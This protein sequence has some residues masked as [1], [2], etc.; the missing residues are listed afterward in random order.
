MN[1][2]ALQDLAAKLSLFACS[3]RVDVAVGSENDEVV[4]SRDY[5]DEFLGVVWFRRKLE[6][7]NGRELVF[8]TTRE[9]QQ[10]FNRLRHISILKNVANHITYAERAPYTQFTLLANGSGYAVTGCN[11]GCPEP[12]IYQGLEW[13]WLSSESV[14]VQ[15]FPFLLRVGNIRGDTTESSVIVRTT[16]PYLRKLSRFALMRGIDR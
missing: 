4:I 14:D 13:E 16:G 15:E 6:D 2:P 10:T 1:L 8:L 3:P 9:A 12:L 11:A 7:R 5:R